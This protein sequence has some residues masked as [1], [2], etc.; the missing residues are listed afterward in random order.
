MIGLVDSAPNALLPR[1]CVMG[2]GGGGGNAIDTMCR[3]GLAGV[4]FVAANTDAQALN[5]SLADVKIQL[6]R[7]TTQGLGAGAVRAVGREAAEES[8]GDVERALDGVQ[9]LFIAAGMGGGTGSGSAPVIARLARSLGILTV[10][11][12]TKPFSFEGRRRMAIA[13]E[14]L[15]E[16]ARQVDTLIVVPNQNLFRT[17]SRETTLHE[18]FRIADEVLDHGVRSISDL[19]VMPGLINL[20]FADVRVVMRGMGPA[21]IGTGEST[22]ERRAL[23]AAEAAISNPLLDSAIDGATGLII[24]IAGGEDMRLIEVDEAASR[25]REL[26]DPE[27]EIIWGSACDPALGDRMRVSIIATGLRSAPASPQALRASAMQ[28]EAAAAAAVRALEPERIAPVAPMPV[29][30][31]GLAPI[32]IAGDSEEPPLEAMTLFERIAGM[33][34][35]GHMLLDETPAQPARK[36]RILVH[37]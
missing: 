14:G 15:E 26:V 19:I 4:D 28:A 16:L 25:I 33:S 27:A 2:I 35:A 17:A 34:R 1:L 9:M 5:A 6:G 13:D 31:A 11:V 36:R 7:L 8:L 10:A 30:A 22:G 24:S 18:A 32:E 23:E 20:D 21:A 29:E 3:S 12:V 37:G